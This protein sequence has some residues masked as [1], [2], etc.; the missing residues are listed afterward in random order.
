MGRVEGHTREH[1]GESGLSEAQKSKMYG[2]ER[3][4][5]C[6]GW[7]TAA[8]PLRY[9][10]LTGDV[11][12]LLEPRTPDDTSS[13]TT[14][15]AAQL[16]QPLGG[17]SEELTLN[18]LN[19]KG[20]FQ[21]EAEGRKATAFSSLYW[22][23]GSD[24]LPLVPY[25]VVNLSAISAERSTSEDFVEKFYGCDLRSTEMHYCRFGAVAF[26]WEAAPEYRRA[27]QRAMAYWMLHT[28][29]KFVEVREPTGP[30]LRLVRGSVCRSAVG[31][32]SKT[33]QDVVIGQGCRKFGRI[34]RLLARALGWYDEHNR[35]DRDLYVHVNEENVVPFLR[36]RLGKLPSQ[37]VA[38][39]GLPYDF[40]SLMHADAQFLSINGK[41]TLATLNPLLQGLIGQSRGLS[42]RDKLLANLMYRCTAKWIQ[43]CGLAEERCSEG[44]Y[45][46]RDCSCACPAGTSGVRCENVTGQ[47]YDSL[48]PACTEVVQTQTNISSP[49]HPGNYDRDIWCVKWIKAPPC[50]TPVITFHAFHLYGRN[51]YRDDRP[52]CYLDFLEIRSHS[53]Y[54]GEVY[55][56]KEI[57]SGQ[58]FTSS[59][60]DLVLYFKTQ[61]DY[62]PGWAASVTFN[63]IS[64][65]LS[66]ETTPILTTT[67]TGTSSPN[68]NCG[69][70]DKRRRYH[71]TSP[72][73]PCQNYPNNFTCIIRGGSRRPFWAI[74]QF[75]VF[76]L[77]LG[78]GDLVTLSLPFSRQVV[79]CGTRSRPYL[80]PTF[81]F[82]ASFTTDADRTDIG[83]NITVTPKRS[84]CHKRVL[85]TE[86]D[87]LGNV[88]IWKTGR[89]KQLVLCEW[90]IE[91][92]QGSRL[93][94]ERVMTTLAWTK[95]CKSDYLVINGEGH[96]MYPADSSVIYCGRMNAVAPLTTSGNLL[97]V[98]YRARVPWSKGFVLHYKIL[99]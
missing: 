71:W 99:T 94:V 37:L 64:G 38:D 70:E 12:K 83:F 1:M 19:G 3:R 91:A 2:A 65:C 8:P 17:P 61:T 95:N 35:P 58:I 7:L 63:P 6:D 84:P 26:T 43:A 25:V 60:G 11:Q 59:S 98:V 29:I 50:Y 74:F 88:S 73:F 39:F 87:T 33:G 97:L 14:I 21:P 18:S 49:G 92:P 30:H 46:K 24:G 22:P 85:L 69:L 79:F 81:N 53:L 10:G 67:D 80:A 54:S 9:M 66:N 96:R 62:F 28:C 27:V 16:N 86:N 36:Y 41:T 15:T 90:W 48:V 89:V 51:T 23:D 42:H 52:L 31:R 40:T 34:V 56:D 20:D 93:R 5:G 78:C 55:C 57:S 68:P 72:K 32:V 75:N 44:G 77:S 82:E 4:A 13:N 47:Y 76:Q 45:T